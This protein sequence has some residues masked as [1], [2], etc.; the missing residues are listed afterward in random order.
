MSGYAGI[1]AAAAAVSRGQM[2][3]SFHNRFEPAVTM[4]SSTQSVRTLANAS[5]VRLL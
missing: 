1:H 5:S 4:P 2:P 3:K